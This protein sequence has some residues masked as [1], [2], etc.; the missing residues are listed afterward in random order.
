MHCSFTDRPSSPYASLA[1]YIDQS[2]SPSSPREED[3]PNFEYSNDSSSDDDDDSFV[4]QVG[5][6][7]ADI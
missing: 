2:L 3:V 4:R 7:D 6:Q 5:G 1:S